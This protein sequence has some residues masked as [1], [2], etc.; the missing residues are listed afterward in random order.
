MFFRYENL[1]GDDLRLRNENS[2]MVESVIACNT[3]NR[4]KLLGSPQSMLVA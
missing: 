2:L 4:L 3:L 1:I